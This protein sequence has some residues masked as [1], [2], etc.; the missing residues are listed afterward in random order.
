MFDHLMFN[1]VQAC[2]TASRE[3]MDQWVQLFA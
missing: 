1:E 3:L 2:A